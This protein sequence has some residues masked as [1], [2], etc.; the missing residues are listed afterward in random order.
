MARPGHSGPAR[1]PVD[2]DAARA[3]PAHQPQ[4]A[5]HQP[6]QVGRDKQD[7][8]RRKIIENNLFPGQ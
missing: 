4:E 1:Q 8:I 7:R 6:Q 2:E 3:G 5:Q